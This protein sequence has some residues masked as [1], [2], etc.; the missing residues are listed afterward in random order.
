MYCLGSCGEH[1]KPFAL[2]M[3]ADE[4]GDVVERAVANDVYLDAAGGVDEPPLRAAE[5][6]WE[7]VAGPALDEDATGGEGTAGD[8]IKLELTLKMMQRTRGLRVRRREG[9]NNLKILLLAR[10]RWQPRRLPSAAVAR[11]SEN[12]ASRWP[13]IAKLK[14]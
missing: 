5:A 4:G 1:H 8:T 13:T 6:T 12:P 7:H 11:P 2:D 14:A 3:A 10:E 9:E